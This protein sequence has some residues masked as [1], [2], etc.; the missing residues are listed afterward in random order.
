MSSL[1]RVSYFFLFHNEIP[2][3]TKRL[4]N[5]QKLLRFLSDLSFKSEINKGE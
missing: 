2:D 4:L 5:F 1:F 3:S